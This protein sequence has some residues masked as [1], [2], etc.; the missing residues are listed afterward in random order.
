MLRE[1]RTTFD[2]NYEVNLNYFKNFFKINANDG[3]IELIS[4]NANVKA[5]ADYISILVVV[6][7]QDLTLISSSTE[8]LVDFRFTAPARIHYAPPRFIGRALRTECLCEDTPA[9][10]FVTS[11]RAFDSSTMASAASTG[12]TLCYSIA[13]NEHFQLNGNVQ[14]S[15]DA[16]VYLTRRIDLATSTSDK[17]SLNMTAMLSY[18]NEPTAIA[19]Q[20]VVF[21]VFPV[22]K[23]APKIL[24]QVRLLNYSI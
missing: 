22:N 2:G 16:D 17:S 1:E 15:P 20:F 5:L 24:T 21:N 3:F 11:L 4:S 14:P 23:F 10:S 19:K 9:R 7:V 8:C 13:D 6:N 18:C 12:K